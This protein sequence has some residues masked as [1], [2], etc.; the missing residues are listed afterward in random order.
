M[1]TPNEMAAGEDVPESTGPMATLAETLVSEDLQDTYIL[2]LDA[3]AGRGVSWAK[4]MP[5]S[6]Y[7]ETN[8][9]VAAQLRAGELPPLTLAEPLTIPEGSTLRW[10]A[11]GEGQGATGRL[12]EVS[13]LD[14][15]LMR[16]TTTSMRGQ[17]E[18]PFAGLEP[19]G[20]TVQDSVMPVLERSLG[21]TADLDLAREGTLSAYQHFVSTGAVPLADPEGGVL[22]SGRVAVFTQQRAPGQE[23]AF[24]RQFKRLDAESVLNVQ[25][26]AEYDDGSV[27]VRASARFT[28]RMV[29]WHVVIDSSG[30]QTQGDLS[31]VF[32]HLAPD[33]VAALA[34]GLRG[35]AEGLEGRWHAELLLADKEVMLWRD[36]ARMRVCERN[37]LDPDRFE[38]EAH[39]EAM[40]LWEG[41]VGL[42]TL[43][44]AR[45]PDEVGDMLV[46]LGNTA[47][48]A[49]ESLARL[50]VDLGAPLE[51]TLRIA[52][53]QS[54]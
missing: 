38:R 50:M 8:V 52:P 3:G 32:S 9:T 54:T 44:L 17:V 42:Q 13:R 37:N 27:E 48:S 53:A 28:G 33:T 5:P 30:Q 41:D 39:T 49:A 20:D 10:E 24:L 35:E 21:R 31:V 6:C 22:R 11:S 14:S 29:L 7:L 26:S 15:R 16:I 34:R 23:L 43:A 47:E 4:D 25:W 2:L 36:L 19:L 45:T 46:R 18:D 51:G 12:H 1:T 40:E